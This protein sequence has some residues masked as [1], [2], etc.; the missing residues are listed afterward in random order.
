M[1]NK[2]TTVNLHFTVYTTNI[3][4]RREGL[5]E[6]LLFTVPGDNPPESDVIIIPGDSLEEV[7]GFC[8]LYG[9]KV[10][11]AFKSYPMCFAAELIDIP[12]DLRA[13]R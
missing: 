7:I 1:E 8:R 13:S 12:D 10:T 6:V 4:Q 3:R 5:F 9:L 2:P 11:E